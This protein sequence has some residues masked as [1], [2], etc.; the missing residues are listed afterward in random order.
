MRHR[1]TLVR[2][3]RAIARGLGKRREIQTIEA[4]R[5]VVLEAQ[6]GRRTLRLNRP[7]ATT[8][9]VPHGLVRALPVPTRRG[10]RCPAITTIAT[11]SSS[12][13]IV[14]RLRV[15]TRRHEPIL[16]RAATI[17][18]RLALTPHRAAAIRLR[19]TLTPLPAIPAAAARMVAVA[20]EVRIAAGAEAP[21]AAEVAALTVALN[22]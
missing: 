6:A 1:A 11:I 18:L 4:V 10:L 21:M 7:A 13:L 2:S 8:P 14:R 12:A 3:A 22:F 16:H 20:A 15:R 9:I 5:Q 19:L 17:P